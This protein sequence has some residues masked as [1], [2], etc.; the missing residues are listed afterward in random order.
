M[1]KVKFTDKIHSIFEIKHEEFKLLLY[2]AFFIF[3]LFCSYALLRPIRDALGI[4]GGSDE[5]KWL[6]LGTFIATIVCSFVAM[7][8]SGAIRRKLYTDAIFIFFALNLLGF[9]VAMRFI[10]AQSPAFATLC[11]VFY[12]WVSVFNL[13]VISSAWSVLA[14]VFSKETSK[15]MFGIIS[16]GA[17][18]G[19]ITGAGLVSFLCGVETGNFIFLSAF[20]LLFALILKNLIIKESLNLLP[21]A[22]EKANFTQKFASPLPSKNPL[23]GFKIIAKSPYLLSFAGFV[24]LLTS[25]S[26]FLYMEQ[27]RI[28]R[29]VFET[30][31]ARAAAFANIDLIVQSASFFIQIFLTAKIAKFFGI[32]WL[33]ALLGFVIALGFIMLGFTHPAFW[34][35]ALVM[36]LRRIGEYALVKPAREMLFVPLDSESKYK[37]KNFLDTVVYRGGDAHSSQ[38]EGIALAKFGVS[39][40]LIL[41]AIISFVWGILGINL[42]KKYEKLK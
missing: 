32:K 16:A 15:S 12:I 10:D 31:E 35:I 40:V 4:H 8:L 1:N 27:A 9:F 13:F 38:V 34:G 23:D 20:L 37:V 18:L 3:S 19:G 28:V 7:W 21:N 22:D 39:G 5:L 24:L 36:S 33:L 11:R 30:R 6:F 41:G 14:D 25:V 26:T 29:A 17:S 42:S 2:S